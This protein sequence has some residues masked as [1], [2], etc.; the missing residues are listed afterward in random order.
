M[1]VPMKKVTVIFAVSGSDD[2]LEALR[3]YGQFHPANLSC[4]SLDNEWFRAQEEKIHLHE[5]ALSICRI[6]EDNTCQQKVFDQCEDI[7]TISTLIIDIYA[8]LKDI[9]KKIPENERKLEAAI[10]WGKTDHSVIKDLES[11]GVILKFFQCEI[12]NLKKIPA[13]L[14]FFE[15]FR[16]NNKIVAGYIQD[17]DNTFDMFQECQAPEISSIMLQGIIDD[18]RNEITIL[19]NKIKNL[20]GYKNWI[21]NEYETLKTKYEFERVKSGIEDKG[22]IGVLAGFCPEESLKKLK[23]TADENTWAILIETPSKDDPVPTL[24]KHS[25]ISSLFKPVMDFMG[26]V[27]S[28]NEPDTNL[29]FLFFFVFFFAILV[30]DAGY[31]LIML[32]GT[33][34]FSLI[35]KNIKRETFRLFYVLS[36]S[37]MLWGAVT[38]MWFGSERIAQMPLIRNL[39]N[40]YIYAFS[41]NSDAIITKICLITALCQLSIAHIWKG[42]RL[43]PKPSF[44]AEAGW[45]AI[46]FGIYK[47]AGAMLL[48]Y[49]M[50]PNIIILISCGGLMV[51]IFDNTGKGGLLKNISSGLS[52]LPAILLSGI[53][54]FSDSISYIRL[55]AVGLATKEMASA[56]NNLAFNIG[57]DSFFSAFLAIIIL[58]SGHAVNILLACMSVMVHG[59]RLN[60]LEFSNHLK[61]EWAGIRYRPFKAQRPDRI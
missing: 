59:I 46:L 28:Y 26:L 48:G 47:I 31:G 40:P 2:S 60:L 15:V 17:K 5:Q 16:L 39:I 61:M 42:A 10:P 25:I 50:S 6:F 18:L 14:S 45:I 41:E 57:F 51:I 3:E 13:E 4:P 56:F 29:A 9:K 33:F 12:K 22:K 49:A 58:L 37:S 21:K 19:E 32:S 44:V 43:F 20:C 24:T 36:I 35:N 54:C 38:G 53:G 8:K 27:P 11:K 52:T 55:F 34:F 30:G 1:I 7:E 23:Q